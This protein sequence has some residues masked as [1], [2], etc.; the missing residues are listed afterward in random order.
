MPRLTRDQ[1][2]FDP[3]PKRILA[4]DGG[5]IRGIFTLQ[6]LKKIEDLIRRRTKNPNA[7]LSDYFDLIGGTSTGSIIASGLA[8]GWE[9]KELDDLYR[10]LGRLIFPK[11]RFRKG[12]V[13]A[14]FSAKPLREE[15]NKAFPDYTLGDERLRTGLAIVSKRLDT[16]SPWVV[17]NNPKGR[18]F[19]QRKGRKYTANS[20]YLLRKLIRAS[21][22]APTFFD[23][24]TISIS[25]DVT[26]LFVDGGV[27]P[28]NNPSLQMFL[29]ATVDRFNFNWD[30][31]PDN[32]LLVSVGTGF[33]A[34]NY[35]RKKWLGIPIPTPSA[36]LA[37]HS[38]QSLM[39]D[40]S[41]LNETLL[42]MFSN[43]PT[44]REFDRE[45]GDAHASSIAPMLSY[46]RYDVEL[47]KQWIKDKLDLNLS[48]KDI[49]DLRQMD[50]HN[51]LD[52]LSDLGTRAANNLLHEDH[53]PSQFDIKPR[54]P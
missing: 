43:S 11:S 35:E 4:L 50:D 7:R 3:G 41:H 33:K 5:G 20:E 29:L 15:L 46:L 9:V 17:F 47:D 34:M 37:V 38:L 22:A 42:Q 10:D 32:L 40:A 8:L 18:Y 16:G 48:I 39:D 25:S 13:R 31:K 23:P 51:M 28:H 27:S 54:N 12:L 26:G 49:K 14:K 36:L 52:L 30:A 19:S 6:I 44:A 2:L 24:E 21:T 53:F 1:H 45:I